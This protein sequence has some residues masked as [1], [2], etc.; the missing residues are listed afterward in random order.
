MDFDPSCLLRTSKEGCRKITAMHVKLN[1]AVY[2][3]FTV[4]RISPW[5]SDKVF[6]QFLTTL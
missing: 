4:K 2:R 3:I 5:S 6:V 1:A